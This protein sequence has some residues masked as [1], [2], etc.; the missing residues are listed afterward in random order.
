MPKVALAWAPVYD[1]KS[2]LQL[3]C[4]WPVEF[5][6]DRMASQGQTSYT[7][8]ISRL[9]FEAVQKD[10]ISSKNIL[11]TKVKTL[12]VET[13]KKQSNPITLVCVNCILKM[14]TSFVGNRDGYEAR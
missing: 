2:E 14:K 4:S 8:S 3:R 12:R 1:Q 11:T 13:C 7:D 9:A 5:T 6:P 10:C